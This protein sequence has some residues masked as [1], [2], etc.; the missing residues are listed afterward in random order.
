[1]RLCWQ[2]HVF[3][4]TLQYNPFVYS[5]PLKSK[6]KK[7]KTGAFSR[8]ATEYSHY[9]VQIPYTEYW[10]WN[11]RVNRNDCRFWVF[12]FSPWVH[13]IEKRS[14]AWDQF[15]EIIFSI[16]SWD[17]IWAICVAYFTGNRLKGNIQSLMKKASMFLV[18]NTSSNKRPRQNNLRETSACTL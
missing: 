9:R 7:K 17:Q 4:G 13:P 15:S 10:K 5:I 14:H 18:I 2:A 3:P 6:S 12:F 11:L 16:S 8:R 1:M